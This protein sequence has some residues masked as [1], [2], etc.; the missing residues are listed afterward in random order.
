[1]PSRGLRRTITSP[2]DGSLGIW[3]VAA[4]APAPVSVGGGD[5]DLLLPPE[6]AET[7]QASTREATTPADALGNEQFLRAATS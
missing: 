6:H 5:E 2:A 1:M 7:E 4:P 3:P